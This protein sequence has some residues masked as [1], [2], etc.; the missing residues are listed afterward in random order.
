MLFTFEH[1][2]FDNIFFFA[3]PVGSMAAQTNPTQQLPLAY[4]D[5]G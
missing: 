5:V 4:C 3:T 1:S 2:L